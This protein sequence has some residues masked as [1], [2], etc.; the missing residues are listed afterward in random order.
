MSNAVRPRRAGALAVLLSAVALA[1]DSDVIDLLPAGAGGGG[2][3]P[4]A[5]GSSAGA[6]TTAGS[7]AG[8]DAT[9]NGG[10]AGRGGSGVGGC[11]GFGCGNAGSNFA[12]SFGNNCGNG[13]CSFCEDDLQCPDNLHCSLLTNVCVQCAAKDQCKLGYSCDFLVGRCGPSCATTDECRDGKVCDMT[14]GTCVQCV[15]N[16]PC[17]RDNDSE[18]RICYMR[19]CVQCVENTDCTEGVRRVCSAFQQCVECEGD[20]DCKDGQHCDIPR[21]RCE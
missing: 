17:E 10:S 14:Q 18:T 21:G 9:S 20:L 2:G 6:H 4:S 7:N 3:G 8:S 19:R 12:G 11:F 1:C 16:G 15:D 13:Q 5:G